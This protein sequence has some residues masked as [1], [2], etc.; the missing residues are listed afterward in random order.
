MSFAFECQ[1]F[2]GS[3]FEVINGYDIEKKEVNSKQESD[4]SS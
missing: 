1:S 3:D 4:N 2:F